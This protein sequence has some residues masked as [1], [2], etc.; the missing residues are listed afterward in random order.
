MIAFFDYVYYRLCVFYNKSGEN[1][2]YKIS[3][4]VLL[5]AIH[6]FNLFFVVQLICVSFH[7]WPPINKYFAVIPYFLLII[8]NGFRYNKLNYDLLKERW[9]NEDSKAHQQRGIGVF[10]YIILSVIV[11]II[12]IVW[13]AK[14]K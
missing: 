12:M 3:G 5:S 13:R 4:L 7:Y 2:S 8:V 11:V 9:G 6:T 14:T 1:R 10:L